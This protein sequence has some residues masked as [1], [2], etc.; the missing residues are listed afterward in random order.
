VAVAYSKKKHEPWSIPV[1]ARAAQVAPLVLGA[2]WAMGR[3][4]LAKR[5]VADV[6][7]MSPPVRGGRP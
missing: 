4:I 7:L 3:S 6:S 5:T 2:G 1:W